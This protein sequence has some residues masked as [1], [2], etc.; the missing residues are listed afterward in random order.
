MTTRSGL[1]AR[2]F[3]RSLLASTALVTIALAVAGA[4][5]AAEA[6]NLPTGGTTVTGNV[7]INQTLPNRL[8]INQ[9]SNTAI[10]NWQSFS[11]GAG[12]RVDVIQPSTS[13]AMLAR[14]TGTTTSSI[15]GQLTATGQL[16][17]VNPNGI[18]ITSTG[19]VTAGSG[20]VAT[21]LA[22]SNDDFL[23]GHWRLTG[24]GTSAEVSNAGTITVG[25]GGYAAL[26]G[27]TVDNSGTIA[28][29]LGKV[30]LG[31][32]ELATLDFSGD[33]FLQVAVPTAAP[34]TT[35]LVRN[36]GKIKSPGG[37]VEIK[38]AAAREMAR[39]AINMSGVIEARSITGHDGS[40]TLSGSDGAVKVSG[41]LSV[42]ARKTKAGKIT[43]TGRDIALTGAKL[44]ASG[45][46]GGTIRIGGDLQG[47]GTLAHAET[48]SIDAA[49]SI[50]A[51][52]TGTG[53]GGDIV[54]WS[55]VQTAFAGT[56]SATGGLLGGN[57][58]EVEVSSH[59]LLAYSGLTV[60]T[61]PMGKTGTLLLDPY[62]VTISDAANSGTGL[63]AGSLTPGLTSN[64]AISTLETAL[65]TAN[66]TITTGTSSS[67][68]LDAGNITLT[69]ASNAAL[70]WSSSA[71]LTLTAANSISL[72]TAIDAAAGGLTLNAGS[73]IGATGAI[74][75]ARFTLA[76][77]NWV[78]NTAIL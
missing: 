71:T 12:Y 10:T 75:L 1:P 48:T 8:T 63:N 22:I 30:G 49:T 4:L 72:G 54:V 70:R 14:V 27:G 21:T 34:G 24:T 32:G 58:G 62:N 11:I 64:I 43:V 20:F 57:G 26:I 38:A 25:P 31:S 7:T 61:A 69:S 51:N 3:V 53:N 5:Q 2:F 76:S 56:I 60:L 50:M 28:V 39:Q 6:Q 77:G 15:A 9:T 40:I 66:V 73:T 42:A 45:P 23:S 36:S 16:V 35:A 67:P 29:P 47:L 78:Q 18:A 37:V 41:R 33:G 65:N 13:S 59:G 44:D 68:G 19:A 52:A 17:L 55:D 74:S 46:S